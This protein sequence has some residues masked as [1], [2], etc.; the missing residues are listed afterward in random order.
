[1]RAGAK[2]SGRGEAGGA[3]ECGG[4]ARARVE[5]ICTPSFG[6]ASP[7]VSMAVLSVFVIGCG[8]GHGEGVV[9]QLHGRERHDVPPKRLVSR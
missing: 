1:M 9:A 3:S 5:L 8:L 4:K 2:S 6:S 7:E